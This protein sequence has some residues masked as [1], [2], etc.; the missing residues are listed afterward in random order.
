M[1]IILLSFIL[2]HKEI[3]FFKIKKPSD[4]YL[5]TDFLH[6][7]VSSMLFHL[8]VFVQMWHFEMQDV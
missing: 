4:K 8:H 3:M 7:S 2:L 5:N 6:E 1:K